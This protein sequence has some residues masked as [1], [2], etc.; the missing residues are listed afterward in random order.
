MVLPIWGEPIA[1][2]EKP[3]RDAR[4]LIAD[5]ELFKETS[6]VTRQIINNHP[7]GYVHYFHEVK[8]PNNLIGYYRSD[9]VV[10]EDGKSLKRIPQIQTLKVIFSLCIGSILLYL[11]YVFFVHENKESNFFLI[12][13]LSLS[14]Y[15]ITKC[16]YIENFS[17][18]LRDKIGSTFRLQ[19]SLDIV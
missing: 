19:S 11:M 12:P 3:Q 9:V 2:F 10:K 18:I 17:S 6:K 7:L 15:I 16:S 13:V 5:K 14:M 8:G 4:V 1:I